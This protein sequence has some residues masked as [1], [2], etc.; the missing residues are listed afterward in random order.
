MWSN[1]IGQDR[2]IKI[3][4]NIHSSDKISHAYIFYGK[5]GVGKD[6]VAIEFAKLLNCDN[7]ID[8]SEACDSCASCRQINTL[9]STLFKFIIALPAG[10]K[11]I[12]E[13]DNPINTLKQE[14]YEIY[15]DE[16]GKKSKDNYHKINIP[17]AND[18]RISSIRQIRK[19]IYLTG[20][21]GKKKIFIISNSDLMNI[22]SS[23]AFLKILEE[24][25]GDSLIILTTSRLNSM[26]STIT[27][28]CQKIRFDPIRKE[29]MT[30]FLL[31]FKKDIGIQKAE[32]FADISDGSILKCKSITDSYFFELRESVIDL[33][34]ALV[35]N[36]GITLSNIINSLVTEKD[37]EKIR[38]FL[39]LIIIWFRDVILISN[40]E[41][42]NVINKDKLERLEKFSRLYKTNNYKIINYVEDSYKEL[43]QNL[44]TELLLL[45]LAFKIKSEFKIV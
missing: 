35:M 1:I 14:D 22:Q 15:L 7:K 10:R 27:G 6:A 38:Q 8:G 45:N 17:N 40:G 31:N 3:L 23:N 25:P 28:R 4:K 36:K 33:L 9:N 39:L 34:I 41:T 11:E 16:I 21:K 12:S 29:D 20:V 43:D 24:P 37:K 5:E 44:N 26:L 42:A 19:E 13:D 32:L 18:I 30:K 2:V